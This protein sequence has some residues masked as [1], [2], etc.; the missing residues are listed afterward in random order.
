MST[1]VSLHKDGKDTDHD[2]LLSIKAKM[3]EG[4]RQEM[5]QRAIIV[6]AWQPVFGRDRRSRMRMTLVVCVRMRV[7]MFV[8]VR[9][10][11]GVR[12]RRRFDC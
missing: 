2:A 6:V 7:L 5:A 9:A 4:Q 8:A 11:L 10:V 3:T 12:M 1:A